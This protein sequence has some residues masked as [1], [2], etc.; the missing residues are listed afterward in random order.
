V[1]ILSLGFM[2]R[3]S[4]IVATSSIGFKRPKCLHNL[5]TK[6]IPVREPVLQD[7]LVFLVEAYLKP[8]LGNS[9]EID[10]YNKVNF[11]N[12]CI[13]LYRINMEVK[14]ILE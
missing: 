11:C 14:M 6:K 8:V 7:V 3:L 2:W 9:S 10:Y 4:S 1:E 5:L 12:V 13:E